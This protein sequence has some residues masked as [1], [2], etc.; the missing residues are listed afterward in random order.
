MLSLIS[1]SLLSLKA[2]DVK[3]KYEYKANNEIMK[4]AKLKTNIYIYNKKEFWYLKKY[5]TNKFTYIYKNNLWAFS[6][7]IE[8]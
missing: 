3:D 7:L 1:K 8:S 6:S 4:R 2:I 5:Y